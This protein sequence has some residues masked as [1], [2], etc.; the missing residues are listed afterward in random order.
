MIVTGES[1]G[2][3]YGALLAGALKEMRP[4]VRVIGVGGERMK[5]A[6][7]E[8]FAG[9]Q[10]ALG[11]SEVVSS[12]KRLKETFSKTVAVMKDV[13]PDVAVL[14]DYPDFNLRV[15]REAK[16]LGVKVLYYVSPQVW[17]W[18]KGRVKDIGRLAEFV[19]V[20]L[21]FEEAIYKEQRIPCEFV[22][23]PIMEEIGGVTPETAK[24]R[25]GLD[26]GLK[27]LALLPGSRPHE[28]ESLLPVMLGVVRRFK[29]RHKG[30]GFVMPLAPNL[31][32]GKYASLLEGLAAE[33][34]IIVRGDAVHALAASELAVVASG[35][36]ALQ[37]AFLGVP[38]VVVY[39]LSRLSYVLAKL[40][41]KVKYANLVNIM[42]NEL[43]VPELLQGKANADSVM[44]EIERLI[45]DTSARGRMVEA[46]K[47]VRA[48]FEGKRPSIRVAEIAS[49]I[50]G[51]KT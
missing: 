46:F 27:Y 3:M 35:T 11:I 1:S 32:F 22:G 48:A 17:A 14:I 13:R 4:G 49:G 16:R 9:F 37:A 18:R 12:L 8:V 43:T 15:A 39:K 36:A 42:M 23:H 41:L 47:E 30:F 26:A 44:S 2:E 40:I 24:R 21:P 5:K 28:L 29:E 10:S 51:W 31:E 34:V 25:L 20:I 6:G 7:V 19:A 38:T 33:G 50:A 45:G